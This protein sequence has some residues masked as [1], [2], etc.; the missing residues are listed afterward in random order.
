MLETG[1]LF[2]IVWNL[3]H[4][5]QNYL[6]NRKVLKDYVTLKTGVKADENFDLCVC[7]SVCVCVDL[8]YAFVFQPE[9]PF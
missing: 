4:F 8:Y 3:W 6:M 7:V 9:A 2:N 5:V 1:L